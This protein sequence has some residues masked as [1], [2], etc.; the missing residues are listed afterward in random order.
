[1]DLPDTPLRSL[2][3]RAADHAALYRE[4]TADPIGSPCSYV[5]ALA[6]LDAPTPR[7]GLPAETVIDDLVA[8][9]TPGLRDDRSAVL[10]LGHRR[11]ASGWCRG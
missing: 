11:L 5:E 2:F 7:T 4:A 8:T 1:M 3:A 9:A 10:W 6:L